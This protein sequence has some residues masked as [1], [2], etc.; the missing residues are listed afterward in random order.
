MPTNP[1][2]NS[3]PKSLLI[4]VV[5]PT[6]NRV[7]K[8]RRVLDSLVNEAYPRI[9]I[10]VCDGASTDGTVE[11]LQS[12]GLRVRWVSEPDSGE[13]S[14]RNKG[15]RM[16]T[17]DLIRYMSDDDYIEP[18]S[19]AYADSFFREHAQIDI[20]FNQALWLY[21]AEDGTTVLIDAKRR[22]QESITLGNFVCP[23]K[24][25][26]ASE[27]AYFRKTVIER[28]GYFDT[29]FFCA[30]GEFWARAA[31][32]RLGIA[33]SDQVAVRHQRSRHSGVERLFFTAIRQKA[34]IARKYARW[35]VQLYV[36]FC[37]IPYMHIRFFHYFL[38]TGFA[39]GLRTMVWRRR[40]RRISAETK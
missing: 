29:T 9:E 21:E 24:P 36:I 27:S 35:P 34:R 18:G 20:L 2:L 17:G 4:S 26:P 10:I 7:G 23:R 40:T 30:D 33:I 8:L 3:A 37:W 31:F 32:Y 28:I 12:F 1:S 19:F 13:Y 11:L 16:A 39:L 14:A 5:I 25:A 6:R 15:L 38:P 22:T